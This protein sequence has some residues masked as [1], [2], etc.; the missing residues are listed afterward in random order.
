MNEMDMEETNKPNEILGATKDAEHIDLGNLVE[1]NPQTSE[2]KLVK[3][4]RVS[5]QSQIDDDDDE[6][7]DVDH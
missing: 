5:D 7:D 3:D 4:E 2:K 6:N 1:I